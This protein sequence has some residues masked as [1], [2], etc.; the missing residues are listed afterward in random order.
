MQ[1][2]TYAQQMQ[3][4]AQM[5]ARLD[6]VDEYLTGAVALLGKDEVLQAARD[7]RAEERRKVDEA[8]SAEVA[9]GIEAGWLK[10]A[11]TSHLKSLVVGEEATAAGPTRLQVWPA[12][13][14]P[15][16]RGQYLGRAV[17]ETFEAT[18]P[19]GT[20]STKIVAI[21]EVDEDRRKQV[22][23]EQAAAKAA[24]PAPG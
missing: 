11:P 8:L 7:F 6:A 19:A 20:F 5:Q 12:S 2:L 3:V 4:L 23:A 1:K 14:P 10:P 13:L 24:E 22:L 21:Y 16:I 17:G 9:K 15:A 18:G